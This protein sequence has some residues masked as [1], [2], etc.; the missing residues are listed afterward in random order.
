MAL[1]ASFVQ[2][3]QLKKYQMEV[4]FS[5]Y[6]YTPLEKF[7]FWSVL[8][9]LTS[10]TFIATFLYLPQHIIFLMN[11]AWFYVHG[12]SVDVLEMTKDAV[13]TLA[14]GSLP[15]ATDVAEASAE[16]FTEVVAEAAT[17]IVR[18]L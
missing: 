13:H 8:F 16:A 14:G 1:L 6:I 18:E 12:D 5:V 4:T 9:L 3:L 10:L 2:W 11:R 15:G 7:I 17:A